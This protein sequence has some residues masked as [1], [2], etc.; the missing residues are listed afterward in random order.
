M[1]NEIGI[2]WLMFRFAKGT[3]YCL[4]SYLREKKTY[5]DTTLVFR[6]SQNWIIHRKKEE[7]MIQFKIVQ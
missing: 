7:E 5:F 3:I 1:V 4:L 2:E 6:Q